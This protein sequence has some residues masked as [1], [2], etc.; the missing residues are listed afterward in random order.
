MANPP[1]AETPVPWFRRSRPMEHPDGD[2][3]DH[4]DLETRRQIP[5]PRGGDAGERQRGPRLARVTSCRP[6]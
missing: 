6:C 1:R 4:P 5:H 2:R 3:T